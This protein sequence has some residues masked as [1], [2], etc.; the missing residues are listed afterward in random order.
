MGNGCREEV[1]RLGAKVIEPLIIVQTILR[2]LASGSPDLF[3]P[4]HRTLALRQGF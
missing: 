4:L 2:V 3:S 1:I